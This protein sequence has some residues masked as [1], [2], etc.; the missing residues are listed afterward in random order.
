MA[1][2]KD[3]AHAALP[4]PF[5]NDVAAEHQV[6]YATLEQV[7]DLVNRQP[8]AAHEVAGQCF[9]FGKTTLHAARQFPGL[10][11]LQELVVQD[12]LRQHRWR[13][14]SHSKRKVGQDYSGTIR[15]FYWMPTSIANCVLKCQE[16]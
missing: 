3:L 7:I 9:R 2:L 11:R 6:A 4:E 5:L 8:A 1:G 10:G 12:Q 14:D 16:C 15:V 13:V